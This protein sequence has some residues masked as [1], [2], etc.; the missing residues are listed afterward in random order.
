MGEEN[1]VEKVEQSP[2]VAGLQEVVGHGFIEDDPLADL[3]NHFYPESCDPLI[4]RLG[5]ANSVSEVLSL[6]GEAERFETMQLTQAVATIQHLQKLAQ[7]FKK[8]RHDGETAN[9]MHEFNSQLKDSPQYSKLLGLIHEHLHQFPH[10]EL[11]FI[12]MCLSRFQEPLYKPLLR[13]IFLLLQRNMDSLDLEALSY[14]S[15][16]LRPNWLIHTERDFGMV[17]RTAMAQSLPRLQH[18]L[19][20]CASPEEL[21]QVAI[22][23][24]RITKVISYRMLDQLADK[25][26]WMIQG[27]QLDRV[28]QEHLSTMNKSC[29]Y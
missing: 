20:N 18:H 29:N 15:V 17:W 9:L 27:G 2:G 1:A 13:D 10:N 19:L 21:K 8:A 5:E 7:H 25:A 26:L 14:L 28:D 16:G 23:F 11:A 24:N 12:L 6:V 3:R 22:C 4:Q